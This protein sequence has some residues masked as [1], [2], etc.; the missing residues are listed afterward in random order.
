[1][2]ELPLGIE[3]LELELE[4]KHGLG[5]GNEEDDE[6]LMSVVQRTLSCWRQSYTSGI[7]KAPL[8]SR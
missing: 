7:S 8:P 1:M 6:T 5:E 3:E 2:A 4:L